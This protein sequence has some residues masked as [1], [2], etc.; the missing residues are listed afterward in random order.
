LDLRLYCI[1]ISPHDGDGTNDGTPDSKNGCQHGD[2]RRMNANTKANQEDLS[3]RMD[4]EQA[5]IQEER[6]ANRDELKGIMNSFQ[7]K[8]NSNQ[9]EMRYIGDAWMKEARKEMI[10]CHIEM[11]TT[12]TVLKRE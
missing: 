11:D 9:A 5:R 2:I 8:M 4:T 12:E 7:M 3:A 10:A 6:K 1:V